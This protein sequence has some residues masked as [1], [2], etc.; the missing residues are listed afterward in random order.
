MQLD[1]ISESEYEQLKDDTAKDRKL[2][3]Y[4]CPQLINNRIKKLVRFLELEHEDPIMI[5]LACYHIG[6]VDG[7]RA[8]RQKRKGIKV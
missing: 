3:D 6:Y 2:I 4:S 5:Y 1:K 7:K 8:K